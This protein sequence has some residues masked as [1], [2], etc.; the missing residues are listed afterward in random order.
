MATVKTFIGNIKGP[1][2]EQGEV[3]P[4]GPQGEQGPE[5]KQGITGNTGPQGEVG[6]QGPQG[7]VGKSAYQIWLDQGNTGTAADFLAFLKGEKGDDGVSE[8]TNSEP[9]L[10]DVGGILASNHKQG[11]NEMPIT[12]LITELLYP[13]IKPVIDSFTLNPT[14]GIKKKGV[15]ITLTE[16]TVKI[17]KKSKEISSVSLY[18]GSTLLGTLSGASINS[19]GTTLEFSNL[20]DSLDG[21]TNTTYTVKVSEKDGTADVVTST[22][23]YTF[24]DPY[25]Q[26]VIEKDA[27]IDEALI[28]SLSEKIESKGAKSYTYTTTSSQCAVIAYPASYGVLKEIKDQNNFTQTWTR[29]TVTINSVSYYVYVSAASAATDFTYKFSY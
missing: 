27:T 12:D 9:L 7:E 20:S 6:P 11:F 15:S 26:G 16:A 25:Y 22:A 19:S 10:N 2:G 13:Y 18:R 4:Q 8:Y 29:Y 28:T 21:T 24:V 23:T 5:G 3:G 1:K 14:S 17:T